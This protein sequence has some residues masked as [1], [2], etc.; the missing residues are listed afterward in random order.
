MK[1]LLFEY[2]SGGGLIKESIPQSLFREGDLM[3]RTLLDD[4]CEIQGIRLA[5]MRDAR[6]DAPGLRAPRRNLEL[7]RVGL[8]HDFD[9]VWRQAIRSVDAVWPIAPETAGVLEKLCK[10]VHESGKILL[11]SPAEVVALTASKSETLLH[12]QRAGIDVVPT[13]RLAE[14]RDQFPAPWV[15]K[16]DDGAGCDRT[17]LARDKKSIRRFQARS[18]IGNEIIQPF[19]EGTA[20]SL[21]TLFRQG[22]ARLLS[23]NRQHILQLDEYFYLSGCTV[24]VTPADPGMFLELACAIARAIPGLS[25]YAGVDFILAEGFPKVL[26]IN[27][28]LTTSYAG[29][30]KALHRN[31]AAEVLELLVNG[32]HLREEQGYSG[33]SVELELAENHAA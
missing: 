9:E 14:F 30:S 21:S 12:L 10:D 5:V 1:I 28:R 20:M 2:I 13:V 11:N 8:D 27:P 7:I 24:N 3:L 16:P 32:F 17:W 18:S 33:D 25:G 4:L 6:L 29:L 26:E 31:I 23:C 19:V 15:I 22:D